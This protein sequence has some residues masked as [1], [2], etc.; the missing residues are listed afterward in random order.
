[1]AWTLVP[2]SV[3]KC[4]HLS[5]VNIKLS[6]PTI[7]I[8]RYY[9]HPIVCSLHGSPKERYVADES[10]ATGILSQPSHRCILP[11]LATSGCIKN[12]PNIDVKTVELLIHYST[13]GNIS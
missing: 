1:M 10:Y 5:P 7:H 9:R 6:L 3:S 13:C 11:A 4:S 12:V 8:G 2:V